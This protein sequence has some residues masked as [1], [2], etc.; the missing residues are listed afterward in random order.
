M[1]VIQNPNRTPSA[2]LYMVK[3][4]GPCDSL[5]EAAAAKLVDDEAIVRG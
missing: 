5:D 2:L 4:L 1:L 3:L